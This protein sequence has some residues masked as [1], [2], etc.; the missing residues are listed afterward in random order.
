MASSGLR[1]PCRC[2]GG[3]CAIAACPAQARQVYW[4]TTVGDPSP[5]SANGGVPPPLIQP[6]DRPDR[7]PLAILYMLGATFVFTCTS[8]LSK[9]LIETYPIGEILFSRVFV[10]L[11]GLC[12]IIL[13]QT[14][15]AVFRTT[16]IKGHLLR[17][18]SQSTSQTFL[19]IAFSLMP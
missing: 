16:R 13:P 4:R 6:P 17:G 15:L 1:A 11:I 3:P 19:L 5:V 10:P 9:W 8:A 14:G 7:A 18:V 12:A 2:G